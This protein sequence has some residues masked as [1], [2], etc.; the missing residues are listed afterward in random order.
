MCVP[1]MPLVRTRI[2][3][4]LR[5]MNFGVTPDSE[6]PL[7]P[8]IFDPLLM[9]RMCGKPVQIQ[10][11]AISITFLTFVRAGEEKKEARACGEWAQREVALRPG[12]TFW[13]AMFFDETSHSHRRTPLSSTHAAKCRAGQQCE[14]ERGGAKNDDLCDAPLVIFPCG[15]GWRGTSLASIIPQSGPQRIAIRENSIGSFHKINPASPRSTVYFGRIK[16]VKRVSSDW[17]WLCTEIRGHRWVHE[18]LLVISYYGRTGWSH[19]PQIRRT[20]KF[21]SSQ[22]DNIYLEYSKERA[23]KP[24]R[25]NFQK[26]CSWHRL[27]TTCIY[28]M[29]NRTQRPL[30]VLCTIKKRN[31]GNPAEQAWIISARD[32]PPRWEETSRRPWPSALTGCGEKRY[33][34]L[35]DPVRV[36][37]IAELVSVPILRSRTD[38]SVL[39]PPHWSVVAS[40]ALFQRG[41]DASANTA[42][43][44]ILYYLLCAV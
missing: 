34:Q 17:S 35:I 22:Q 1:P 25:S 38:N 24:T 29:L 31:R 43:F 9:S 27:Q 23:K 11:S 16:H 28:E 44:Q 21:M 8:N 12:K 36:I 10:I 2:C 18:I 5:I 26:N 7:L 37:L 14:I 4:F 13:C 15:T 40:L 30:K 33:Y 19:G 32:K 39:V 20:N 6:P 41:T 3:S 42:P